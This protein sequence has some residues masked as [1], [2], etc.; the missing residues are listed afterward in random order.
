M[1]DLWRFIKSSGIYFVGT[2]LTKLVSFLLLP[3]YTSYID[4]AGYGTYDLYNSYMLFFCSIL[5][6]D[7]WMGIMRF[8]YEYSG[9][10][11]KK[12]INCG[13]V[14][15]IC[16]SLLYI[17]VLS[18]LTPMLNIECPVLVLV[19]GLLMNIQS[20]A[21]YIV[22]GYG[23]NILYASSGLIAS[24]VTTVFNVI[25]LVYVKMD[26]SALFIASSIGYIVNILIMMIGLKEPHLFSIKYF[27]KKLFKEMLIFSAPLC[28][29]SVAY[30]FLTSYDRI[31]VNDV[32]GP[33]ANGYYAVAGRFGSMITLFTSCFHLA[34]QELAYLKSSQEQNL[35]EFYSTAINSYIKTMGIGLLALI[36]AIY[37]MYPIMVNDAYNSGKEL[38]PLYLLGTILSAIGT[39]LGDVFSAIK[40]NQLQF[41]TMLA[42]S[43]TNVV[44]IHVFLPK[45]GF[46]ASNIALT[47]GFFVLTVT[48][49]IFLRNEL[50]IVPEY[51]TLL[52]LSGMFIVV[53]W[54]YNTENIYLNIIALFLVGGIALYI[55]RD[56]LCIIFKNVKAFRSKKNG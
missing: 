56:F 29:N 3:L 22:R 25:L 16:S 2:V 23:K 46:Q 36:P 49:L 18:A 40:K 19:C 41:W 39:F 48:R 35:G 47:A 34:W 33:E 54:I 6:L 15:F 21:G 43:I 8:M 42:G 37:I 53:L 4:P 27:D 51:K 31:V 14:I 32:L 44:C 55:F 30:W 12:P 9:E 38:I 26:Y 1:K 52:L 24:I 7:I 17:I 50:H 10:D 45:I 20:L 11:R 5:F 28:L 13:T